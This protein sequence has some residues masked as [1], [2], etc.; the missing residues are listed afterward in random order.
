MQF[1]FPLHN[2][3][4]S[5]SYFY[6]SRP[7]LYLLEYIKIIIFLYHNGSEQDPATEAK[8]CQE[9]ETEQ[10]SSQLVPLQDR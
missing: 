3:S 10:A 1:W 5:W 2:A 7:D 8:A 9:A 6:K 4:I